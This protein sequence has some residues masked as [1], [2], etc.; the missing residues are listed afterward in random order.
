MKIRFSYHI[1]LCVVVAILTLVPTSHASVCKSRH[2]DSK[3]TL[4]QATQRLIDAL[5]GKIKNREQRLDV[6][7][8][9]ATAEGH[10]SFTGQFL[11]QR[12]LLMVAGEYLS[13]GKFESSRTLLHDVP[14]DS[15]VAVD[16]ALLLAESWRLSGDPTKAR[17]WYLRAGQRFPHELMALKGMV[18][19]AQAMETRSPG[20]AAALYD[21][22]HDLAQRNSSLLSSVQ[23]DGAA[24]GLEWLLSADKEL[25]PTLHRQLVQRVLSL[26]EQSVTTLGKRKARN[27]SDLR[28]IMTQARKV[29]SARD[30]VTT[31]QRKMSASLANLE[32]QISIRESQVQDLKARI[33]PGNMDNN[34]ISV[35]RT[36]VRKQNQIKRL[37]G[38]ALFLRQNLERL[39]LM[40]DELSKRLDKLYQSY[41]SENKLLNNSVDKR[42]NEALNAL[43]R[44]FI[45]TAAESQQNKARLLEDLASRASQ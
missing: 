43:N 41:H 19:A 44:E 31:R 35:R 34:Q 22:V 32:N 17:D 15:P 5:T 36:M 6:M 9:A 42:L 12:A 30:T 7:Y 20:A 8:S 4:P 27:E 28:C 40:I 1:S 11:A 39:P 45:N 21:R 23:E 37:R 16:A 2:A 29:Q 26:G 18:S 38:E 14:I 10:T 33:V 24:L 25:P 3:Q 13:S